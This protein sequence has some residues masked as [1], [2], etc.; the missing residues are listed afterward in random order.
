MIN[1]IKISVKWCIYLLG[2]EIR[3]RANSIKKWSYANLYL[4]YRLLCPLITNWKI[5]KECDIKLI[6]NLNTKIHF[7][8]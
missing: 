8:F 5:R 4:Y 6:L 1:Y 3:K 7:I 2:F